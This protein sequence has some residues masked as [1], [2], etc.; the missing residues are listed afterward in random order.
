VL[1]LL[2]VILI[3]QVFDITYDDG[4]LLLVHLAD[5]LALWIVVEEA[6]LAQVASATTEGALCVVGNVSSVWTFAVAVSHLA[7]VSTDD[8]VVT[9]QGAIQC[10]QFHQ[11]HLLALVQ[12]FR[13]RL[14]DLDDLKD[15]LHGLSHL[16]LAVSRDKAVQIVIVVG[17]GQLV[18][19][20]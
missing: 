11:L 16:V 20:L 2:Y 5:L 10:G 8:F 15:G 9:A 19:A 14:G 18:L 3:K 13:D 4:G 7:A 1:F 17:V 12:L 6:I